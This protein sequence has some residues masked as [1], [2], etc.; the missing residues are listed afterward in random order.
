MKAIMYLSVVLLMAGCTD[1]NSEAVYGKKSGLP[2]NC[3]AYVQVV[4]DSYRARI[5]S[6]ED[7]FAGLERNCGING[8][9]WKD[10]REK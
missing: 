1:D 5:H 10:N 4:I 9:A 6:A 2:V 7:S 3:R 8:A